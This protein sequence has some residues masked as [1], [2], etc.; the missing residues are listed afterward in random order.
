ML[1]LKEQIALKEADI[2]NEQR[3]VAY[4]KEYSERGSSEHAK[5]IKLLEQE[6]IDM[7]NS[8]D[9]MA[10]MFSYEKKCHFLTKDII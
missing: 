5:Q 1:D 9:E 2:V 10:C 4:W 3:Q 8:H 7:Q 6:L